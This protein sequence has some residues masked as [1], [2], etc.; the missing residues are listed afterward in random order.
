MFVTWSTP[1]SSEQIEPT[2]LIREV[3]QGR[4]FAALKYVRASGT[5]SGSMQ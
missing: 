5:K 2:A 1:A 3:V 4:T